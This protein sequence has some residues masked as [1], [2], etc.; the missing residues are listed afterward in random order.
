MDRDPA[1]REKHNRALLKRVYASIRSTTHANQYLDKKLDSRKPQ[2]VPSLCDYSG[3]NLALGITSHKSIPPPPDSCTRKLVCNEQPDDIFIATAPS[4]I[5]LTSSHSVVVKGPDFVERNK[6]VSLNVRNTT[7][8]RELHPFCAARKQ[9]RSALLPD[10][11]H[12]AAAVRNT[13]GGEG[14]DSAEDQDITGSNAM[15]RVWSRSE[16]RLTLLREQLHALSTPNMAHTMLTLLPDAIQPSETASTYTVN[17]FRLSSVNDF[18]S[19]AS[20]PA[21]VASAQRPGRPTSAL[22]TSSLLLSR[23]PS[24]R[25]PASTTQAHSR[26]SLMQSYL[27][28]TERRL[29][30]THPSPG[31]AYAIKDAFLSTNRRQGISYAAKEDRDQYLGVRRRLQDGVDSPG[32]VYSIDDFWTRKASPLFT[33]NASERWQSQPSHAEKKSTNFIPRPTSQAATMLSDATLRLSGVT[34]TP[35][36]SINK[37]ERFPS[38]RHAKRASAVEP[39]ESS[40]PRESLRPQSASSYM[41]RADRYTDCWIIGGF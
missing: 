39:L 20:A 14:F 30:A 23:P 7:R 25:R 29:Q 37:T 13:W 36:S 34:A 24:I 4:S 10:S 31:P 3:G 27:A 28:H 15:D 38:S 8:P 5:S 17:S 1:K 33:E 35:M 19:E 32:P 40:R 16:Q 18:Q 6:N 26:Q 21:S 41:A 22:Q 2:A 11:H 12:R 9:T